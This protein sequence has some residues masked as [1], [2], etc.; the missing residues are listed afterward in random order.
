VSQQIK[1]AAD[2]VAV[3][4]ALLAWLKAITIPE[5]AAL[6]AGVYTFLRICELVYGW[7]KKWRA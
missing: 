7:F 5:F 3:P 6:L 4:T 1:V 2:T